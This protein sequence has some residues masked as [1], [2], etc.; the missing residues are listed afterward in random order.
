MITAVIICK[1][2]L[3]GKG[4]IHVMMKIQSLSTHHIAVGKPGEAFFLPTKQH[5][6]KAA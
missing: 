6:S 4:F 1:K 3:E 5:N 2:L